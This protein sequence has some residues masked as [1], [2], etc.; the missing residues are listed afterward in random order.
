MIPETFVLPLRP[1][2]FRQ[3]LVMRTGLEFSVTLIKVVKEKYIATRMLKPFET[4]IDQILFCIM[5]WRSPR[6]KRKSPLPFRLKASFYSVT[7]CPTL[8][9]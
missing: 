7:S 2:A 9:A 5:V 4:L 1:I 8:V 6:V 3:K